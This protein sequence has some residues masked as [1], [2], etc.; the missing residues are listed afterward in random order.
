M[1]ISV[2][3]QTY[4]RYESLGRILKAW[5]DQADEVFL[6]DCGP[7]FITKLPIIHVRFN[8]D[9]GNKTRHS[10][11]LLTNGD[12]VIKADDDLL[13]KPGLVDDFRQHY[14]PGILGLIGRKFRGPSYYK[15]TEFFKS[16]KIER[17]IKVDF[18]GV[19]TYAP[20]SLMAFDLKGCD[21]AVEDLFWQVKQFRCV[22]KWVIPTKNYEDLP[23]CNDRGS[24]FHDP[25]ARIVREKFYAENY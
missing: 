8:R 12:F 25:K 23:E 24:L 9:I 15:D 10:V 5:L 20:R 19:C 7:G 14:K 4:R 2:V 11:A 16:S 13:P 1:K 21:N 22:D 6:A 3:I 18:V 17:P